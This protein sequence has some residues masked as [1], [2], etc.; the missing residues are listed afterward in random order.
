[1]QTKLYLYGVVRT[2]ES[3]SLGPLGLSTNG[4]PNEI[5]LHSYNGMGVAY[6]EKEIADDEELPASRKNLVNH[7]RVVELMMNDYSVLPFAFGTILDDIPAMEA[8]IDERKEELETSLSKIEGMV[9]LSL[10]VLWEKMEVIFDQLISENEEINQKRQYLINHNIHDQDEKIEL[11]KMVEAA[12]DE[13]KEAMLKHVVDKLSPHA[14]EHKV[15]KTISDAMFAN[16][17]FFIPKEDEKKF[18]AL[19]NELSEEMGENLVFKYVGPMAPVN[20]I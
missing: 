11:G 18:D 5:L 4:S 19:V 13:K 12:L 14:K 1:M 15:Q 16:L 10:K 7:Q 9:E 8:L 20:F 2:D 6:L 17:A 3:K